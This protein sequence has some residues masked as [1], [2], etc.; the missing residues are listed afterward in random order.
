VTPLS[1]AIAGTLDDPDFFAGMF[2]EA[3][4][5]PWRVFL[6]ALQALPLDATEM[7]VYRHHTGRTALPS[8]PTR[9]AELVCGRRGGKSRVLA[10]I[11]TYL[12]CVID[13]TR[14]LVPGET[15]VIAIIARDRTQA[16]V[17]K[18]YITG[19]IRAVPAFAEMI[20]DDLA[21]TVRLTSGVVVEVHTASI[22]APRGRT[23]LAVL[24]DE[25]AFWPV[26]D[27]ANPDAEVI[28][29]VRPGLATIPYSLLLIASSPYAKR[30]VLYQNYARYFGKDDAPV[31]VWQGTTEEMNSSLVDD[32]LIAEMYA[33]DPERASAEFGAQFR[34]D[35][36]AFIT[37]EAVEDCLARGVRELP[38]GG[39]IT[40]VGHV[41]PSG[42]SADSFTLAVAHVTPDGL[43][44]LDCIR[45]VKPPF[46]PDA[47]VEEF[48]AVL[49]SYRISRVTG[50]AY[51]G[52]WPRERFAVHGI[53][54]DVSKKN[55]S[56]IYGEFL[57]ALNARRVQ[58]LDLPRLIGQLVGLERR[59]ARG[60]RDSIAH[61]PGSHDDVANVACGALVQVIEDRRPALIKQGD[62][63][64]EAD[65]PVEPKYLVCIAGT[66]WVAADGICAWALTGVDGM[67]RA[68]TMVLLDY[69][70]EPWSFGVL[71]EIASKMDE[72]AETALAGNGFVHQLGTGINVLLNVPAQLEDAANSALLR[73]FSSRSG[74]DDFRYRLIRA[75]PIEAFWFSDQTGTLL[76][77][78]VAV[79][80]GRVKLSPAAAAKTAGVPLLGSLTIKPGENIAS[81]PLRFALMLLFAQL[82]ETPSA[83]DP[84][85]GAARINFG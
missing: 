85:L 24:A 50:D 79:G 18:S 19:F 4:W 10:L 84:G 83:A 68:P 36:V 1:P 14:Y 82:G 21:E 27:S 64:T 5:D 6:K 47:V 44:V 51:A 2:A 80:E 38:P 32:P 63:L 12:A 46:S 25:I 73:A 15:P 59:T 66:L 69:S 11:A 31:L 45:E 8:K 23:F 3:S 56:A 71:D 53:A 77:A 42:G 39:G 78:T 41:D 9:Y 40:Y 75:D 29:A 20:A 61:A 26:G 22:G 74:R 72:Y 76:A 70:L 7:A 37:R 65:Q 13:H 43:A 58:L 55:T 33:E 60:G 17:I 67:F 54:Y 28:N 49:K 16:Q 81:D 48:A 34:S 62:L 52:E 30:G 35:I 57:P